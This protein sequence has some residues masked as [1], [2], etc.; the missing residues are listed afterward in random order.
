MIVAG[1]R[2]S[3]SQRPT[4]CPPFFASF[5]ASALSTQHRDIRKTFL[6][7]RL[8]LTQFVE[9]VEAKHSVAFVRFGLG[10]DVIR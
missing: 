3:G 1:S 8:D 4:A 5:A 7:V 6:Q 2:L 10:L 9:L